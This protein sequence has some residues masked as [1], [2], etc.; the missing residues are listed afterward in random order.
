MSTKAGHRADPDPRAPARVDVSVLIPVRNEELNLREAVQ[1]MLN[2]D[3]E[4]AIEF[5][6]I[7]GRSDDGTLQILDDLAAGDAR[8][9]IL[10][11]PDGTTPHGLNIGLRN[12]HGEFVARMDAHTLYPRRYLAVGVSRLRHGDAQWVSGPQLAVG[13]GP[14]SRRIALALSSSLGTGGARF[15]RNLE[16]EHEVDTGFTGVWHRATLE[17]HGGWDEDWLNDQDFELAARI[18]RD[19]GRIVCIPEMAASY[20]PRERLRDLARQYGRYGVYR[21]KT[22]RRHP[23]SMRRSHV[24]PPAIVVLAAAALLGRGR[25]SRSARAGLAV[26]GVVLASAAGR[27]ALKARPPRDAVALPAVYATMHFSYGVGFLAGCCRYGA[28]LAGIAQLLR[29]RRGRS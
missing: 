13:A 24:L 14:G 28:P 9:R 29:P 21:V 19:G 4:G 10:D 15:R 1:A 2:Q 25:V 16:F 17:S 3:F 7:E 12:A 11:N 22:I 8:I 6:F 18:R 26:Y 23:E 27:A 5:L 20:I